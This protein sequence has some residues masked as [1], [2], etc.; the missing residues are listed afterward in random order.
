MTVDRGGLDY[1]I[2]VKD[3]FSSGLKD[4]KSEVA[5]AKAEWIAFRRE[6]QSKTGTSSRGRNEARR[7]REQAK[8]A[9][10]QLREETRNFNARAAGIQKVNRET[11]KQATNQAAAEVTS[12]RQFSNEKRLLTATE[13]RQA[14]EKRLTG[15]L[16][17]RAQLQANLTAVQ[18]RG[19]ELSEQEALKLGLASKVRISAA[20]KLTE[21]ETQKLALQKATARANDKELN[22][23]TAQT[24]ALR[25]KAAAQQRA[26]V[27]GILRAEGL[28]S[29]GNVLV[30]DAD[31]VK[32]N[33]IRK[34]IDSADRS[35]NRISFTFRRLFGILAAFTAARLAVAGFGRLV[36]DSIRLNAE[37]EQ[38][39]L[40]VGALITALGDVVS[41]SG[42]V[43]DNAERL[44]AAQGEARRQLEFLRVDALKTAATYKELS[45][46]FQVALAPGFQAGLDLDEIRRLTV[47]ISQAAGAIGLPQNQL[48]E[49][50]RSLLSGTITPRTTRIATSLGIT[51]ED[52]RK[53]KEA[54]TLVDFLEDR[55]AAFAQA[56]EEALG[57]FDAITTNLIDGL[58]QILRLGGLD[59]F[60]TLKASLQEVLSLVATIDDTGQLVFN[61]EAVA[62]VKEITDGLKAAVEEAAGIGEALDLGDASNI[63]KIIG[64]T[65]AGIAKTSAPI[66]QA[67]LQVLSG[68]GEVIGFITS[69]GV[70]NDLVLSILGRALAIAALL[71][72]GAALLGG[73]AIVRG[74]L[75]SIAVQMKLIQGLVFGIRNGAISLRVAAVTLAGSLATLAPI[76][77]LASFAFIGLQTRAEQVQFASDALLENF[78]K[79]PTVIAQSTES[80][81]KQRELAEK[82]R[83]DFESAANAFELTA[84]TAGLSGAVRDQQ[85]AIISVQQETRE[86]QR[87]AAQ[88]QV[89]LLKN[90]EELQLKRA[91]AESRI[92]ALRQT[93]GVLAA[94]VEKSLKKAQELE[95]RIVSLQKT[96]GELLAEGTDEAK[97]QQEQL[98]RRIQ[99]LRQEQKAIVESLSAAASL[100]IAV[101]ERAAESGIEGFASQF[102]EV[103]SRNLSALIRGELNDLVGVDFIAIDEEAIKAA[104]DEIKQIQTQLLEVQKLEAENAAIEESKTRALEQQNILLQRQQLLTGLNVLN[105]AEGSLGDFVRRD[106]NQQILEGLTRDQDIRLPGQIQGTP[107]NEE[108]LKLRQ[109]TEA[110]RALEA[111]ITAL[112]NVQRAQAQNALSF[113]LQE[114]DLLVQRQDL[115]QKT[116]NRLLEKARTERDS[117]EIL[118][119]QGETEE[120]RALA[121]QNY[122]LQLRLIDSLQLQINQK[123]ETYN[124]LLDEANDKIEQNEEDLALTENSIANIF[125]GF[126]KGLEEANKNV[127]TTAEIAADVT[128]SAVEGASKLISDLIVDAFD[129]TK[130][131]SIEERIGQFFQSIARQLLQLTTQALIFRAVLGGTTGGIG[132]AQGG[133]VPTGQGYAAGG[134]IRPAGLPASDTVPI[135]ATPGEFMV[136]KRAVNTYGADTIAAINNMLVDPGSLRSLAGLT[137]RRRAA[138]RRSGAGF[139][140]GGTI[141]TD[142]GAGGSGAA[143]PQMPVVVPLPADNATMEA[144]LNG[145]QGAYFSFVQS[146]KRRFRSAL[147]IQ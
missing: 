39:V 137:S 20:K 145:G 79:L 113:S 138:K 85:A 19:L 144:L 60:N 128:V 58:S 97:A 108:A 31:P 147:G 24:A 27:A 17:K 40:G 143:G 21:L 116:L 10:R 102:A 8:Q 47:R 111:E 5:Q 104:S 130:D 140:L 65:I 18:A 69:L 75:G 48:P 109:E 29:R 133:L 98:E 42:L 141:P 100:S 121:N 23:I 107:L 117:A 114:R 82:L 103:T 71:R 118:R 36:T 66:L 80:L 4:F 88:E 3:Q 50:I 142:T 74:A 135:W 68:V 62:V 16:N 94:D 53:A 14:A 37:L 101:E 81:E 123:Q 86:L 1:S 51:N 7:A 125:A 12:R 15:L 78:G 87:K 45:D 44:A 139:A 59:F 43:A 89:Q 34:S 119:A 49:E 54:G 70:V 6:L 115:E 46:T 32:F 26:A 131:S 38:S 127:K 9:K 33:N 105:A 77:A 72:T 83:E 11:R 63:A 76:L 64:K 112:G 92:V 41:P 22:Q 52:I 99:T 84:G 13:Q 110:R 120:E 57:T 2:L 30:P 28:D 136:K 132:L 122:Y 96:K 95:T 106:P 73:L 91:E 134:S 129:P 35:A 56:G 61:E 146:N 90:Q 67:L 25:I 55:F 126:R 124:A 93:G